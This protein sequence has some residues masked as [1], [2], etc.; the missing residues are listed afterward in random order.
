MMPEE[1]PKPRKRIFI[2]KSSLQNAAK[3]H[4]DIPKNPSRHD[5]TCSAIAEESISKGE[6]QEALAKLENLESERVAKRKQVS[7]EPQS[8]AANK[9]AT[10]SSIDSPSRNTRSSTRVTPTLSPGKHKLSTHPKSPSPRYNALLN[11]GSHSAKPAPEIVTLDDSSSSHNDDD[12]DDGD[13]DMDVHNHRPSKTPRDTSNL[14]GSRAILAQDQRQR[15]DSYSWTNRLDGD[16]SDDSDAGPVIKDDAKNIS[17]DSAK[18]PSPTRPYVLEEP[19][20]P[21]PD[22][23]VEVLV[24]CHI[25]NF[26]QRVPAFDGIPVNFKIRYSMPFRKVRE[27]W[28]AMY[29]VPPEIVDDL[30]L[31]HNNVKLWNATTARSLGVTLENVE[32]WGKIALEMTTQDLLRK[33]EEDRL[34]PDVHAPAAPKARQPSINLTLQGKGYEDVKLKVYNDTLVAKIIGACRRR[35]Q[36]PADKEITIM[37]DGEPLSP[38]VVVKDTEIEGPEQ[39]LDVYIK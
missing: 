35:W 26:E 39:Q 32:D 11:Q 37:L 33:A 18:Y 9:R 27:K 28:I 19:Q 6:E 1:P 13:G 23:I 5:G 14:Q 38:Q 4:T 8:P 30:I 36:I 17:Q 15:A 12:N 25:P 31:S 2:K 34:R 22:P 7:A 29:N 20:P 16:H 24:E 3:K 10:P 21:L